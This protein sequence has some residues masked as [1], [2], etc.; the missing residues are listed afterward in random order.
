MTAEQKAIKSD[1]KALYSKT[2]AMYEDCL[3][4][5]EKQELEPLHVDALSKMLSSF[6][7]LREQAYAI[8]DIPTWKEAKDVQHRAEDL[9][10]KK[11]VSEI[12]A[13]IELLKIGG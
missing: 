5:A 9:A 6:R 12:R 1:L 3:Q 10:L 2:K 8:H 11:E 7:M 4:K 13:E